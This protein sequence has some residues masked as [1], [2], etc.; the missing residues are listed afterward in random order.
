MNKIILFLH[1]SLLIIFS[2]CSVK[3]AAI[4]DKSSEQIDATYKVTKNVAYGSDKEQV[5]DIY[6]SEGAKQLQNNNFTIV[7]LHGG[8]Y[9]VSDKTKEERYIKPY[10][11]K[12]MNVVNLNYR[13]KK[14]IPLA[15]EDLTYALNFLK[16]NHTTYPLNLNKVILTGF[17]AGA[18]IASMVGV[19]ANNREY[20]HKL[21]N[22]IKIS[23]VINFSGPVDGLDMVEKVFMNNEMSLMKEIGNA[24]F[25]FGEG[26]AP[27]DSI[28][29]Y[30]P[31]T[32]F[33]KND[34]PFF[35]W[36][37]GKDDQVPPITFVKFV[38]L[39]NENQK[40]NTVMFLPNGFHSPNATE[41]KDAYQQI[42]IFL[43]QL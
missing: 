14:G 21:D 2:S 43:D 32:Y 17:S 39:L 9:Y 30:E 35:I 22:G 26:Y 37:G 11:K 10:L 36:H 18:H 12:G 15:T 7:F 20:Q 31:I 33:D 24:L 25:Q 27:K 16:A 34:P 42:F 13:L 41:L 19:T 6:L 4:P 29:K 5:F 1:L 38:D 28:I 3:L 8:G 40:K 23:G